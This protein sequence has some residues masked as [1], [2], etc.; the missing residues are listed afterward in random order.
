ML[1]C[2]DDYNVK[3]LTNGTSLSLENRAA[4]NILLNLPKLEILEFKLRLDMHIET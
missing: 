3:S 2:L 4:N 1:I